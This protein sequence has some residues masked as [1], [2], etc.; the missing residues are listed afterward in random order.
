MIGL[1]KD[2]FRQ[3]TPVDPWRTA[4]EFRAAVVWAIAALVF[5]SYA[6][7]SG[8]TPRLLFSI[9]FGCVVL[10]LWRYRAAADV[11]NLRINLLGKGWLFTSL[12]DYFKLLDQDPSSL[13]L[14]MGFTWERVHA[15]RLYDLMRREKTELL[16][17]SWYASLVGYAIDTQAPDSKG[18]PLLHGV[19]DAEEETKLKFSLLEGNTLILGTTG[20]GKTTLLKLI[21]AACIRRGDCVFV[22]DPKGD[23]GL[24]DVMEKA[25]KLTPGREADFLYFHTAHAHKSVRW[26]VLKNFESFSSVASR[27]AA[28]IPTKTGAPDTFS[29]F[30]W[31]VLL[32]MGEL[33]IACGDRPTISTLRRAVTGGI[34][35]LLARA[36]V[37]YFERVRPRDW[38]KEA[39]PWID[40]ARDSKLAAP[41]RN[42]DPLYVGY[43][44]YYKWLA[45]TEARAALD[46]GIALAFHDRAHYSK[47][48][49]PLVPVLGALDAGD[50]S[51]L[52]S[53]RYDDV[54]DQRPVFDV[55][56]AVDSNRAV[57][58]GTNALPDTA[59]SHTL[60]AILIADLAAYAG[61]RYNHFKGV[62]SRIS[63][64][65]DE[66][67]EVANIPLQQIA[68]KGR[69]AG[70]VVYAAS[71]TI[72]D[73]V[74]KLAN[75]D[76]AFSTLGNFNNLVSLRVVDPSTCE[77]VAE[78]FGNAFVD[79]AGYGLNTS[80]ASDAA[81]TGFSG[82][83][84][85]T[86]RAEYMEAVPISMLSRLPDQ[87]FFALLAGG[88]L[89]KS[90]QWVL[91]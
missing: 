27:I 70:I 72:P 68:S 52:I 39:E 13:H 86:V 42:A 11:W 37:T 90:R 67:S 38:R 22:V 55:A 58:F 8:L 65:V 16:P 23:L 34:D 4:F 12:S 73:W 54:D 19:C 62:M 51:S 87:Q 2:P 77:F 5:L 57:Y 91:S 83:E 1:S 59:T 46:Q 21:V 26:D 71:Q 10:S 6:L 66:A 36:L 85:V 40:D 80:A 61:W 18:S 25:C 43:I 32:V 81:G 56:L 45:K 14:G 63:L 9:F 82:G 78:R 35:E 88:R 53:P 47:M 17:P 84:G 44:H 79:Q 33:L 50:M 41:T 64:V 49:P 89:V 15:Q 31:H 48:T 28:Q 24:A 3:D 30:N 74:A 20:A 29:A 7:F 60:S 75:H 76:R 69:G